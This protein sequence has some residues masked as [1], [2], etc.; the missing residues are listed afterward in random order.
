MT[1]TPTELARMPLE[2]RVPPEPETAEPPSRPKAVAPAAKPPAQENGAK[3]SEAVPEKWIVQLGI[4]ANEAN[5]TSLQAKLKQAGVATTLLR[6]QEPGKP[7]RLQ[8]APVASKE[9]AE[10]LRKRL[11]KDLDVKGIV[12]RQP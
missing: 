11:E 1:A 3:K 5:A 2:T 12:K 10:T 8:T 7:F 6:P 4:Y 9:K